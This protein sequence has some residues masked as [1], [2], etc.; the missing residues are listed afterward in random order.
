MAGFAARR[1]EAEGRDVNRRNVPDNEWPG[2]RPKD[3]S[4]EEWAFYLRASS[5]PKLYIGNKLVSDPMA[6]G[7]KVDRKRDAKIRKYWDDFFATARKKRAD[8]KRKASR[9]AR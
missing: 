9:V 3:M 6:P 2:P 5:P 7:G 8:A 4:D 1:S